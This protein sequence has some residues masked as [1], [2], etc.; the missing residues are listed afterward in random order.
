MVGVS[1]VDITVDSTEGTGQLEVV[2]GMLAVLEESDCLA[3]EHSVA[4]PEVAVQ[5]SVGPIAG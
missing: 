4:D 3:A 1:R 2:V 5:R